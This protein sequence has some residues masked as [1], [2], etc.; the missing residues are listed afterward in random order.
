M[1]A[2]EGVSF[3]FQVGG[4]ATDFVLLVMNERGARSILS[5]KVKIGGDIAGSAGPVGRD[6]QA[7]LDV[8]LRTTILTYSRSRGL[9]AGVSLEGSTLRPDNNANRNL[10]G[11]KVSARS[12]VLE[13]GVATP[14]SAEKLI[15]TLNH[16]AQK[17]TKRIQPR[18]RH[19]RLATD[20]ET[21]P[22]SF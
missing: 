17:A 1:M 21:Y 10:Y 13:N 7:N 8:Y 12:I 22:Q 11:K 3:G 5:G 6:A 20:T 14:P 16:F 15:A 2:L 19:R 9:F 18:K 4:Q